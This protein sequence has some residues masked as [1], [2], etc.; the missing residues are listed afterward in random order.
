MPNSEIIVIVVIGLVI[1]GILWLA[2]RSFRNDKLR[3]LLKA[4]AAIATI[5]ALIPA[6]IP[7]L[8]PDPSAQLL[9]TLVAQEKSTESVETVS[10]AGAATSDL[11]NASTNTRAP[12]HPTPTTGLAPSRTLASASTTPRSAAPT[13]T[14]QPSATPTPSNTPTPST[15]PTNT[16]IATSA[17]NTRLAPSEPFRQGNIELYLTEAEIRGGDKLF[18]DLYGRNISSYPI[19]FQ[20]SGFDGT[21]TD[22]LGNTYKQVKGDHTY[23]VSIDPG[24]TK[25]LCGGNYCAWTFEENGGGDMTNPAVTEPYFRLRNI[26]SVEYVEWIIPVYH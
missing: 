22:N 16:S 10:L 9:A 25:H 26:S 12:L 21:V 5:L 11:S 14:P 1:A 4:A 18:L 17:R 2:A 19:N 15:T 3:D 23:N 7:L 24:E 13:K 6:F 20:Y 8:L